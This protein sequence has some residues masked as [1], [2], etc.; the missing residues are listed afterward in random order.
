MIGDIKAGDE[1][2]LV[3]MYKS[4]YAMVRN[5]ILKNSGTEEEIDDVLQDSVIAV[6]RNVNKAEFTLTVKLSTY[7][8]AIVKNLWFKQL[9]K[10]NRFTVVDESVQEKITAEDS[11]TLEMDFHIIRDM[12]KELDETCM[13]L[14]SYFYFDGF[15]NTVIAE[16]LG[17]A[18]TDTVKSKKYQCFKRL[19]TAVKE[20]YN[21]T[22]FFN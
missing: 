11:K 16:K 2:A 20:K 7:L 17:F 4:Y 5:F 13:K 14:L 9:K 22:D 19:Q 15:D 8:M 21:K 10:K 3:N 18:N 1:Q 12:V 6:W